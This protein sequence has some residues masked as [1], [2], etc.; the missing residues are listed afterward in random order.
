MKPQLL[1]R[2][3]AVFALLFAIGHTMGAPWTPA[4]GVAEKA[5]IESMKLLHFDAMGAERSY[6]DFYYG[7]GASIT[8]YLAAQAAILWQIAGMAKTDAQRVRPMLVTLL[9][10]FLLISALTLK[11]FFVAPLVLSAI[12]CVLLA[13]AWVKAG[14]QEQ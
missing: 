1:L 7:F 8:V 6:W 5:L 3:A 4:T 10:S 14:A 2:A 9:V 13:L 11:Y 12:I